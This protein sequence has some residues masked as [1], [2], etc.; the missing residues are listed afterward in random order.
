M[1]HEYRVSAEA[2]AHVT[3]VLKDGEGVFIDH[4]MSADEATLV[5]LGYK[6]E[7]K[8]EFSV[9]TSFGVSFSVLGLL[10]S[11]ASTLYVPI[12]ISDCSDDLVWAW[13]CRYRWNGPLLL[14]FMLMAGMGMDNCNDFHSM[15][16]HV[17][18]RALLKHAD[19]GKCDTEIC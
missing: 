15:R 12:T 3:S 17:Y 16:G 10:P 4:Q 8:R 19:F 14:N 7:F 2:R 6:Q 1:A 13:I 5:A 18:G 11:T 9:W